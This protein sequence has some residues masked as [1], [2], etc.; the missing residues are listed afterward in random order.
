MKGILIA[1]ILGIAGSFAGAQAQV[2][3]DIDARSLLKLNLSDWYFARYELCYE[4]VINASTS[5]QLAVAGIGESEDFGTY[6]YNNLTMM[7][8][9]TDVSVNHSGWRVTPELRRYAWVYGGMPEGV[10]VS[11][12]GRIENWMLEFD[13]DIDDFGGI[14]EGQFEGE[15]DGTWRQFHWGGGVLVGYQWYSDNGISLEVYTGPMFRS[16]SRSWS[17]D[18]T[19]NEEEKEWV[20]DSLEDRLFSGSRSATYLNNNSGPGWR[21]GLTVGLGL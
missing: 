6:R 11:I 5:V 7:D 14:A 2:D 17:H 10:F 12:M 16:Y 13:E 1:V 3:G 18:G 19:L 8:S 15:L 21:F 20:E 9:W 4:H